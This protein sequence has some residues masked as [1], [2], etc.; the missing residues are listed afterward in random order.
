M[1]AAEQSTPPA[2]SHLGRQ[3]P[4]LV[5]ARVVGH[6]LRLRRPRR[7]ERPVE[8]VRPQ[9]GAQREF[10]VVDCIRGAEQGGRRAK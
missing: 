3:V 5:R 8:A 7:E 1:A 6:V 10:A 4:P 2:P 9:D